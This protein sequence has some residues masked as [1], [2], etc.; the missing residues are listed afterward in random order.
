M[1]CH[2][3]GF[4]WS[5]ETETCPACG[6]PTREETS[7]TGEDIYHRGVLAEKAGK[8]NTA[9]AL[10]RRRRSRRAARG[11]GRLPL[12]RPRGKSRPL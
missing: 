3:C 5:A 10:C 9:A 2:A 6:A 7:C 11:M 8:K 12:S 4:E 1:K